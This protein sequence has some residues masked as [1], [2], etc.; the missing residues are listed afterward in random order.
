MRMPYLAVSSR[1]FL[2]S[3][4]PGGKVSEVRPGAVEMA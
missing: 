4:A 2:S 3:V 1:M